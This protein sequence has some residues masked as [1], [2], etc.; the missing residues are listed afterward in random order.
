MG[1]CFSQEENPERTPVRKSQVNRD[2]VIPEVTW[3]VD[4][5]WAKESET[6]RQMAVEAGVDVS[7]A[8]QGSMFKRATEWLNR[9]VTHS[10]SFS[11]VWIFN[12]VC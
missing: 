9:F 11:I 5:S 6:F 2:V 4:E 1:S 10:P 7:A 12:I 8:F 3:E